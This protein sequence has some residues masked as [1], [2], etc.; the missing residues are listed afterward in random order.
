MKTSATIAMTVV[1]PL[2]FSCPAGANV[3]TD[4]AAVPIIRELAVD[5]GYDA[6]GYS[7]EEI[8]DFIHTIPRP[9]LEQ[10]RESYARRPDVG[11]TMTAELEAINRVEYD[12]EKQLLDRWMSVWE[13]NRAENRTAARTTRNPW[14]SFAVND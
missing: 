8:L 7:D 11:T 6:S 12:R 9:E 4:L 14:P 3:F 2:F 10:F 13:K 1:L 5:F